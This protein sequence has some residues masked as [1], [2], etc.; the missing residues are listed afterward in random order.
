MNSNGL[1][2]FG[3]IIAVVA[4]VAL[5]VFI[6]NRYR[7]CPSDKILVIWGALLGGGRVRLSF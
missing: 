7:K 4:V 2:I 1:V 6:V 3:G 5:I